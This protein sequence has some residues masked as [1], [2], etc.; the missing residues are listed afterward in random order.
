MFIKVRQGSQ[1][2]ALPIA[3]ADTYAFASLC[4]TALQWNSPH[5]ESTTQL[6]LLRRVAQL[7]DSPAQ[8]KAA[9]AT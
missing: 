4:L 2:I 1:V 3:P 7:R 9:S 8:A 6:A 5:L